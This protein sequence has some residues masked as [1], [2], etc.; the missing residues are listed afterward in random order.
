MLFTDTS[1]NTNAKSLGGV[2]GCGNDLCVA[3]G[4]I[5]SLSDSGL[6]S[7]L[8][9]LGRY[10]SRLAAR[11]AKLL[12]ELSRRSSSVDAQNVVVGELLI[13]RRE[14][15]KEVENA[16]QLESLPETSGALESGD[17]T[18]GHAKLIAQTAAEGKIVEGELV[19][20]AKI[21]VFDVFAKTVREHQNKQADKD[22][23]SIL[24]RQRKK[25]FAKTFESPETG[26]L[27]LNAQFDQITGARIMAALTHKENNLWR[28]ENPTMRSTPQQRKADALAELILEQ[29][30]NTRSRL[31]VNLLVIADFDVIKQKLKNLRLA[32]STPITNQALRE[33][34]VDANILPAIFNNKTQRLWLGRSQ[35]TASDAQRI[36]LTARDKHCIGCGKDPLWCRAHHIKYWSHGGETNL[37]NLTLVCDHCHHKIHDQD[38][39]ITQNPKT[40]KYQLKPPPTHTQHHHP[41]TKHHQP[42]KLPQPRN[43]PKTATPQLK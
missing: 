37:D 43:K 42:T 13:S 31:G 9:L 12:A 36:A 28:N 29:T 22:G 40:R 23:V 16:C 20:K 7:E 3:F 1:T 5:G 17:I 2:L 41:P 14:A 33:L 34:A 21:E 19:D 15:K 35:R 38:W 4:D 32:N 26:M 18:A 8:S 10:E 39:Q 30:P 11:K 6:T 27:V 24:D 25:R